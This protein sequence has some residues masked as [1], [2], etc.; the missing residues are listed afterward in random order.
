MHRTKHKRNKLFK[1]TRKY[2]KYYGGNNVEPLKKSEGVF[3]IVGDKL[4][5]YT[6]SVFNYGKEKGL[7]LL[8]LQPIHPTLAT[9]EA[10][11]VDETLN[12]ARENASK[13][14]SDVANVFDKGS[15][16]LVSNI[17]EVLGSEIVNTSLKETAQQLAETG[18]KILHDFNEVVSTP[19][20]KQE[21]KMAMDNAAEIAKI[22]IEASEEPVNE[23]IDVLNEA[24]TKAIAGVSSGAIKV[25]TDAMAAIPG[26]GAIVEVGKMANDISAAA[27]DVVEATTT[28]TEATSKAVQEISKNI[29]EGIQKIEE[30]KKHVEDIK[31]VATNISSVPSVKY[32]NVPNF[33]SQN[34]QVKMVQRGGFKKMIKEKYQV[35]GR[36]HESIDEFNNPIHYSIL[37]GGKGNYAKTKKYSMNSK[38]KTKRVRFFL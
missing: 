24:G 18:T 34:D 38:G 14:S 16:A 32:A 37:K 35:A 22:A 30:T 20:F 8:G 7:R 11:K 5:D 36:I 29:N 23:A 9:E 27:G 3:D 10:N 25:A 19:E 1:K 21:T 15:A 2:R 31:D 33:A 12:I 6:S 4:S 26:Y 28:A 17:N 13:I